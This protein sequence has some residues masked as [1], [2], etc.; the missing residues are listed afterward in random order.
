MKI[1]PYYGEMTYFLYTIAIDVKNTHFS[2]VTILTKY[3]RLRRKI[4]Y[5]SAYLL[6]LTVKYD[7]FIFLTKVTTSVN[8]CL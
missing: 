5:F 6:C 1:L 3:L 8:R 4:F 7:I 2:N